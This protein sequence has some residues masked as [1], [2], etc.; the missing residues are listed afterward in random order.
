MFD[1]VMQA[2]N[3]G[4][5]HG[6]CVGPESSRVFAEIIFQ[7]LDLI[8]RQRL[9][10]TGLSGR[11][12]E[13]LR[14]V[15]DFF[16]FVREE[17][18]LD[19]V[20]AVISSVLEESGFTLNS[21]KTKDYTTP[22]T[23]AISERK[24]S[25]KIFLKH[26]LPFDGSLPGYDIR[27][28]GVQLRS[29]M[30]SS[31]SDA[32]AIG[33]ALTQVERRLR[34]FLKQRASKCA[35][36]EEAQEL[37]SYVWSFAHSML[38]LYLANPSV[39][40]SM[41][42][43][44]TLRD[45]RRASMLCSQLTPRSRS[46]IDLE[47][48]ESLHF[49]VTRAIGRLL[50]TSG[51]EIEICQFLSLASASDLEMASGDSVLADLCNL[52]REYLTSNRAPK[53]NQ[54]GLFLLLSTMKYFLARDRSDPAQ[55]DQLLAVCSDFSDLLFDGQFLPPRSVVSHASQELLLLAL[56]ECPFID[57]ARKF[58]LLNK[59]WVLATLRDQF[60]FTGDPLRSARRFLKRC[61]ADEGLARRGVVSLPTL[62]A[63]VWDDDYFDDML[64]EK[65]PQFVY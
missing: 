10:N 22:F 54:A 11:D 2:S 1:K 14:Y 47:S 7:K 32:Q 31:D 40:S 23:T 60:D 6:I 35:D 3:W 27:E 33:A 4:E 17:P 58:A 25:L 15:D 43:I 57:E 50:F 61:I 24:A 45:V 46:M 13:I 65:E 5:T 42:L 29:T 20:T 39:S 41:K 59:G 16:V 62:G 55:V 63:F 19:R 21:S 53:S 37:L 18:D 8:I 34:K 64:Y 48:S 56:L 12:Y 51:A 49:A 52:L 30:I 26:A 36:Y 28:I 38:Y 9:H 44:R